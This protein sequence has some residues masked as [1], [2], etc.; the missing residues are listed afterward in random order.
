MNNPRVVLAAA[1]LLGLLAAGLVLLGT[2]G[3]GA[4]GR[5][6]ERLP[7]VRSGLTLAQR[8]APDTGAE[9]L[10]SLPKARLNTRATT[11]GKTSV[12]LTCFVATGARAFSVLQ[13]WPMMEEFGYPLPHL[14]VPVGPQLLETIRRCRLTGPGIDLEG[15][16]P[17]RLPR[18]P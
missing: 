12:T 11:G 7:V 15:H 6:G 16:V 2:C 1:L 17:G 5:G 9:L 10:I 4:T 18:A 8:D 3:R 13:P 14:H